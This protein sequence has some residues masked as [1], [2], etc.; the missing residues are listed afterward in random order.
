MCRKNINTWIGRI[1][2]DSLL[3]KEMANKVLLRVKNEGFIDT[4]FEIAKEVIV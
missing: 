4:F 1:G 3:I 2:H